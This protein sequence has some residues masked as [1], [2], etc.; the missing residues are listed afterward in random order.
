MSAIRA[1]IAS[2]RERFSLEEINTHTVTEEAFSRAGAL[3]IGKSL[4]T[5]DALALFM[6]IDILFD[7]NAIENVRQFTI[8]GKQ[9][10]CDTV[11]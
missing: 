10:R 6:D 8:R 3:T 5:D 1:R 9:V 4:L 11:S 7:H 2:L